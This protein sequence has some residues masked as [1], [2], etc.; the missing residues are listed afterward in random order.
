MRETFVTMR[1]FGKLF[2]QQFSAK[3][4]LMKIKLR[5]KETES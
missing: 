4:N 3:L 5:L 1:N 2:S